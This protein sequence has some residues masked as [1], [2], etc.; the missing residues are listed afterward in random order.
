MVKT[1]EWSAVTVIRVSSAMK[2]IDNEIIGRVF[3][4]FEKAVLGLSHFLT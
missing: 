4:R 3:K 2:V 1:C